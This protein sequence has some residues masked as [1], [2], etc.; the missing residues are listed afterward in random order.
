MI[1][2]RRVQSAPCF[3]SC[4]CVTDDPGRET[5]KADT[6]AGWCYNSPSCNESTWP[7][8]PNSYCSGIS[9]SP[10]NIE[11]S[12]VQ[13]DGN[14]TELRFKGFGERTALTEIKNTGREVKVMFDYGKMSVEGGDLPGVYNSVQF[15]IHW[16]DGSSSA[17]SEHTVDN[18]RYA[19]ELHI[20]NSKAGHNSTA[21][22]FADPT[23]LAALGFFIAATN[24]TG[25][26]RSWKTLTSYLA[27]ISSAGDSVPL[28]GS[29]SMDSLLEGVN[30]SNYYR[31][32]GSLTVPSCN[33]VVVWTLFKDPIR[34]SQDLIDLFST[35]LYLNKS[36]NSPLITNTFRHTQPVNGRVVSSQTGGIRK[37]SPSSSASTRPLSTFS[38]FITVMLSVALSW[39]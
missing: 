31:Y 29:L 16:G 39:L 21:A 5:R 24:D 17:G 6:S 35:S 12:S 4:F 2:E 30:R 19:M 1:C 22:A 14:L 18:K 37:R 11:S 7:S 28:N 9:Q 23:G 15:H 36:I 8:I 10:V 33:E 32:L 27:E 34:V 20:V 13:P 38:S 3:Y 25:E 26:P